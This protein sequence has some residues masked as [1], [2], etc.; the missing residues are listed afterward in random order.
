M[1]GESGRGREGGREGES[2]RE[3]GEREGEGWKSDRVR[4][5]ARER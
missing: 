2:E 4:S 5:R 1:E 3:V